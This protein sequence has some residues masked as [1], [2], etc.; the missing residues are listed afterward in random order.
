[1]TTCARR[2][3]RLVVAGV[4]SGVGKTTVAVGLIRALTRRGLRVAPFKCGPDYLDPT[5]HR[6]AAG[7]ASHNLDGWMMG[8]EA[9]L[10]TFARG[11]EG[12]DVAVIE[13]VMGLF[14]GASPTDDVGST[15]ELAR[16]LSAPVLLVM[17]ASGMARSA[18]A[19]AHGFATYREGVQVGAVVCNRLGSEGHLRL[20]QQALG[21]LPAGGLVRAPELA[22][23]ERHLGLRTAEASAIPEAHLDGWA[24]RVEVGCDLDAWISLARS[25]PP[26]DID[27]AAAV[28]PASIRAPR[29]RIG[30]ARDEAFHFYYDANL[31]ALQAAGAELV[32]FSPLHDATLPEV[33]GLYLGGG[34]PEV[35]A[36]ALA[37]NRSMRQAITEH[38]EGGGPIYAECG[39][40]MYLTRAI[41]TV[42]GDRFPMAG[43]LPAE[44]VCADRLRALG[45]AEVETTSESILGP[46]GTRFRGHQFRYS[47]LEE[48]DPALERAYRVLG[49]RN[50]PSQPEGFR[51]G[52]VLAS[53]VHGHWASNPEL[54]RNLVDAVVRASGRASGPRAGVS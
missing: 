38:A 35:H 26:L 1:M 50:R 13:G 28:D 9:V 10:E 18:A 29:C 32:S 16:W 36:S 31:R 2:I 3:P 24:D 40:L 21:D 23:P 43:L 8:K 15:A 44:A 42:G 46:A 30:V 4:S 39:G 5:Y 51:V 12:A 17:D 22:F 49:R 41:R 47:D 34:Y 20:L 48:V 7:L 11:A 25:A 37:S 19:V 45:Y 14:D 6:R 52:S 54:P 27:E 53:Y 33:D